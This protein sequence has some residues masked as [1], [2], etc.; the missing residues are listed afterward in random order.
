MR[1]YKVIQENG[2]WFFE[3][4]PNNNNNQPV[5]RSKGY[6]SQRECRKAVKDFGYFIIQKEI[7]TADS[8]YVLIEKEIYHNI[9]YCVFKYVWNDEVVFYRTIAYQHKASCEK[10]VASIYKHIENYVSNEAV[11]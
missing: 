11:E 2:K 7:R 6:E 10:A 8:P 3:L 9:P 1:G 5:G 4:I